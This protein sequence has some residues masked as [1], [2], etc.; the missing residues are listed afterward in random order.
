MKSGGEQG[1]KG[2]RMVWL[3]TAAA[4]GLLAATAS[5]ASAEAQDKRI[6][7]PA[8]DATASIPALAR[9]SG[10]QVFAPTDAVR[11]VRTNPVNGSYSPMDAL[12]RLLAGT[13]LHAV[14]T[15]DNAVTIRRGDAPDGQA[16]Q[17][18]GAQ[19]GSPPESAT[20]TV[21][22]V[23]VTGTR[24]KRAGFDTLEAALSTSSKEIEQRG[25]ENI[26]DALQ[27]TPGF[28]VPGS[29]PLADGQARGTIGQSYANFLGLGSQRTLTLVDGQRFVSSN[30]AQTSASNAS[31][32]D[33]VDLNTIPVG[34]I[35][36]VETIAIGGAPVYGS[37][38][39]A[40]T[41]NIILKEHYEG[42]QMGAQ[43]G[44]DEKNSDGVNGRVSLLAGHNFDGG[45]GNVVFSAEYNQQDGLVYGSRSGLLYHFANPADTG[46]SDGIPAQ[47]IVG[48]VTFPFVTE[49]GLPYNDVGGALNYPGIT[50]PPYTNAHGNYIQNAS[51]QPLQFDKSGNLVPFNVGTVVSGALGGALPLYA[52]GGDGVNAANHFALL[53]P[54]KRA[55]FNFNGHYDLDNGVRFF[56]ESSYAHTEAKV[57]SDI[58]SMD[59]PNLI[60]AGAYTLNFSVNNPYLSATDRGILTA[61]YNNNPLLGPVTTF[62]LSRNMNDIVDSI[63]ATNLDNVYRIVAGFKGDTHPWGLDWHWDASVNYGAAYSLATSPFINPTNLLLA[64]N[65]VQTPSGIACASGGS[66]VPIDLFGQN[67]FSTAAAK[68]VTMIGHAENLNTQLDL[69][70]NISGATGLHIG[71]ADPISFAAGVEHRREDSA[72][73]PDKTWELGDPLDGIPG[74][75]PVSGHFDTYEIYG[76][77]LIPLISPSQDNPLIKKA[78]FNGAIRYVDHSLTGGATT[79]SSGG[80]VQPRLPGWGDGLELRG[81]FTHS[82]RSPAIAEFDLTPSGVLEPLTDPCDA[83]QVGLG[84]DPS[85]RLANCTAAL[86]AAGAKPAG[87]NALLDYTSTTGPLSQQGKDEGNLNL[88]NE[89]ADSWS[90][91]FVY[92]PTLAPRFRLSLDYSSISLKNAIELLNINQELEQCYDSTSY[93]NNP[94]CTAF[95][96]LTAAT[97]HSDT[98]NRNVGDIAPGFAETYFN[99]ATLDYAGWIGAAQY[100]FD[101]PHDFGIINLSAQVAYTTKYDELLLAGTPVVHAA[102]TVTSPRERAAFNADWS[103]ENFDSFWQVQWTS[104]SSI[105][106]TC[107]IESYAQ[108]YI[109]SY[110]LV[111]TSFSYKITPNLKAQIT[112]D[113]VFNKE[114]PTMALFERLF[115]TYDALGRRYMFRLTASF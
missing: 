31:P 66:C 88:K 43:Y 107:T 34:L 110:V 44:F 61:S 75:G 70:A 91:G 26:A 25:Y 16:Q 71:G 36:H 53:S 82:I 96:R 103:Y 112:V 76:E 29:S 99:A 102:G 95:T 9:Q 33:Q 108:C 37:D 5:A 17:T 14:Q 85:V 12:N 1:R 113:N 50:Y 19:S 105:D 8:E 42:L 22:E 64:I 74:Y 90:V 87:T 68:Y 106:N 69:Q 93:P 39:I 47:I 24:I 67:N 13:G 111:N 45:K 77:T 7:I 89:T 51:G 101:L 80:T 32:G 40:G 73:N 10:L 114:M 27:D 58:T 38:A 78:E 55:L 92:Q 79:W 28:G 56:W 48:N 94:L 63:P 60:S 83:H 97:L 62:Q 49:G 2:R 109:P 100:G 41:V 23:V 30:L 84:P 3:A 21:G 86:A 115:S 59:A 98:K 4:A 11:G 18:N 57:T 46:P 72:Y 52:V 6:T 81:V 20:K 65:A 104:K 54:T 35:D 15:G